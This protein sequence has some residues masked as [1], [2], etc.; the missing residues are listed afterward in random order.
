[1]QPDVLTEQ[2]CE[3]VVAL[4]ETEVLAESLFKETEFP[5]DVFT[6]PLYTL[7]VEL[8]DSFKDAE[9]GAIDVFTEPL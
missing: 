8:A 4:T 1:M 3:M 9:D 5:I 7:V 2:W 6:E